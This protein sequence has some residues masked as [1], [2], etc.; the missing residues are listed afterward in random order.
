M[1]SEALVP[2]QSAITP[3]CR[4]IVRTPSSVEPYGCTL[5]AVDAAC[6]AAPVVDFAAAALC[7]P[8]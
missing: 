1:S 3:S 7:V 8:G 6:A 4:T 2:R 5:A